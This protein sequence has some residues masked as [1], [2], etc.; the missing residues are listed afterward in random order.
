M[1]SPQAREDLGSRVEVA[2]QAD[3]DR[4]AWC[5]G[6]RLACGSYIYSRKSD[7]FSVQDMPRGTGW[8]LKGDFWTEFGYELGS[9]RKTGR[10]LG[11]LK[12]RFD[13]FEPSRNAHFGCFQPRIQ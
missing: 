4:R 11:G 10:D 8:A 3:T 7:R 9:E 12:V 5:S 1:Y 2:A 6:V 13:A